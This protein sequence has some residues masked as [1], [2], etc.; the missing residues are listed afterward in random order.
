MCSA[1]G[2]PPAELVS[3]PSRGRPRRRH[4]DGVPHCRMA[5]APAARAA[6]PARRDHGVSG[7]MERQLRRGEH[8]F[9]GVARGGS[10]RATLPP[11]DGA[12]VDIHHAAGIGEAVFGGER[13]LREI[14]R[15]AE[16]SCCIDVDLDDRLGPLFDV[17]WFSRRIGS[18]RRNQRGRRRS[19]SDR[20]CAAVQ[21]ARLRAMILAKRTQFAPICAVRAI[22]VR[23]CAD[24]VS[25][26]VLVL[27]SRRLLIGDEAIGK[28]EL[29]ELAYGDLGYRGRRGSDRPGARALPRSG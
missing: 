9:D 17:A 11:F 27:R 15:F 8:P 19:L 25:T 16:A 4:R 10:H 28:R 6:R 29:C 14:L 22:T 2:T 18:R 12:Q 26:S 20:L 3:A 23:H 1:P 21:L 5:A 24:R 13:R 7:P